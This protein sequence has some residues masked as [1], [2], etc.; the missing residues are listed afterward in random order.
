AFND[1][2]TAYGKRVG[3]VFTEPGT[4][5]I[6]V[7]VQDMSGNVGTAQ[8]T[9][10]V[11][12]PDTVFTG[13]RTICVG[14][15]D[16]TNYPGS[17]TVATVAAA[18]SALQGL[19]QTGRILLERGQTYNEQQLVIQN[20]PNF[21]LGAYGTGARPI[22]AGTGRATGG[23]SI[24]A[25]FSSNRDIQFVG[26]QLQGPWDATTENG[27]LI[28]GYRRPGDDGDERDYELFYDCVF[29][30]LEIAIDFGKQNN[31]LSST[32]WK[33]EYVHN[34]DFP[35]YQ[36]MQIFHASAPMSYL[37]VT[38]SRLMQHPDAMMGQNGKYGS[39]RYNQHTPHRAAWAGYCYYAAVEFF[40]R[41]NWTENSKPSTQSALRWN[42]GRKQGA[43]GVVE[44]CYLEGGRANFN[45]EDAESAIDRANDNLLIEKCLCILSAD[46]RYFV[47]S[48]TNGLTFRNNLCI[49]PNV[50]RLKTGQDDS[51]L[52]TPGGLVNGAVPNEVYS[53]TFAHL[54]SDA[55]ILAASWDGG[56]S[57][58]R[59]LRGVVG[60]D[61]LQNFVDENNILYCP[62]A[63]G[64]QVA[65]EA[66]ST[67]LSATALVTVAGAYS[68]YYLGAKWQPNFTTMQTQWATPSGDVQ[69]YEPTASSPF[70]GTATGIVAIDDFWGNLRTGTPNQGAF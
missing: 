50:P 54:K 63:S 68:S 53:N 26:V 18:I 11:I 21:Y 65:A 56:T 58:I 10:T 20:I 9:H 45:L 24:F 67:G 48:D 59:E 4:W 60:L 23:Q 12:D 27:N 49:N 70:D 51:L 41:N 57:G 39:P 31:G 25:N 46:G 40:S 38:G 14:A 28:K 22:V 69:V 16:Q 66:V 19:S 47:I 6:A 13:N 15:G 29:D 32:A 44:R 61:G 62:N 55:N 8:I 36:D 34:C 5:I 43:S 7:E 42:T 2:N 33:G 52:F 64:G 1:T 37:S 30:G 35:S 3:H 17:Q